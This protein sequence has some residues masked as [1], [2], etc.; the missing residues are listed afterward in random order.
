MWSRLGIISLKH[1][2][3]T[4]RSTRRARKCKHHV[5]LLPGPK[6]RQPR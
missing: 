1:I 6:T 3:V 2:K 4:S 5:A